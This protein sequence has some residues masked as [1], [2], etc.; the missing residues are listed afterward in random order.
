MGWGSHLSVVL[1]TLQRGADPATGE[2][3]L[4]LRGTRL[5]QESNT[6]CG[7]GSDDPM[8]RLENLHILCLV[9]LLSVA[10]ATATCALFTLREDKEDQLVPLCPQLIVKDEPLKFKLALDCLQE[11]TEVTD[12][13]GR[14][15][16]KLVTDW[17][18]PFRPGFGGVDAS[19]R[20]QTEFDVTLAT[21]VA[22]SVAVAGQGLALCRAGCEIFGFVE[23][24]ARD[25]SSFTVR[26]RSAVE[27]LKLEGDFASP[28]LAV[29]ML[30]PIGREICSVR[31]VGDVCY[32]HVY[33]HVD[34][35]LALCSLV[36]CH[37][38]S[39]LPKRQAALAVQDAISH[40]SSSSPELVEEAAAVK[41]VGGGSQCSCL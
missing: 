12:L 22:R 7:P 38:H 31:R 3:G 11:T 13:S 18:D 15:I 20:L 30:N 35:G 21:V 26:H 19:V 32:G 23:P 24:D 5:L 41:P 1:E 27:L 16:C 10:V 14:F 28:N 17:P 4:R 39:E 29:S 6:V 2:L 25:P 34:A 40:S 8:C 36:A 9:A 33:P 37:I